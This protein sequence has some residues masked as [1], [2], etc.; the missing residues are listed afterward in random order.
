METCGTWTSQFSQCRGV[1]VCSRTWAKREKNPAVYVNWGI[2]LY[3]LRDPHPPAA[4]LHLSLVGA[5]RSARWPALQSFSFAFNQSLTERVAESHMLLVEV[6]QSA[7]SW[8]WV[9]DMLGDRQTDR[10]TT[11]LGVSKLPDTLLTSVKHNSYFNTMI[12]M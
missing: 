6:Q 4:V 3:F 10:Q 8:I 1:Q 5:G 2:F 11:D 9:A 7:R 12:D